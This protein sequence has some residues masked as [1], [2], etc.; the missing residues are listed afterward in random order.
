MGLKLLW[1]DDDGPRR[2]QYEIARLRHEMSADVDF[3]LTIAGAKKKIEAN[4]YSFI[5][6]DQQLPPD[7]A[8]EPGDLRGGLEVLKMI[9][10]Q[11]P[12]NACTSPSVPVL[13]VSAY[14]D[15]AVQ[16][17]TRQVDSEIKFESKPVDNEHVVA[18]ISDSHLTRGSRAHAKPAR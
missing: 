2:F 15:E 13:I 14:L 18:A 9:R 16:N 12:R 1:V 7:D 10:N 5:I 11:D 8:G 17:E 4:D 6:L 3:A